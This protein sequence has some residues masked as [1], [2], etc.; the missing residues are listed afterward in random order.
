MEIELQRAQVR[1]RVG[2]VARCFQNVL[3]FQMSSQ[4]V[5][6]TRAPRDAEHEGASLPGSK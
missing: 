4:I 5:T 3:S 6:P 1:D 2:R